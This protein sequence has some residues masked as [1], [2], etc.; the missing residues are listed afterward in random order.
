MHFVE[1][2]Y[3]R[4]S[5]SIPLSRRLRPK[6]R[7]AREAI[8]LAGWN[9]E[10]ESVPLSPCT[11]GPLLAALCKTSSSFSLEAWDVTRLCGMMMECCTVLNEVQFLL[12]PLGECL[13]ILGA[14]WFKRANKL[15]LTLWLKS[16]S[17]ARHVAEQAMK[18]LGISWPPTGR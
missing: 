5:W 18:N 16:S 17:A 14:V 8:T 2:N 9:E 13:Q 3:L 10:Q 4:P 6:E 15:L 1:L 12:D 11:T 7:L